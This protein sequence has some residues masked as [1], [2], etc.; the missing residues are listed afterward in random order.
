MEICIDFSFVRFYFTFQIFL[1]YTD[2][3]R[4]NHE[5]IESHP[6]RVSDI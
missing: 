6:D 2:R 5:E 1:L 3:V 4:L